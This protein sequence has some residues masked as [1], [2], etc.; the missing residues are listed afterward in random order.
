MC[1]WRFVME[2]KEPRV[3]RYYKWKQAPNRS[4]RSQHTVPWERN[5]K[6]GLRELE[7]YDFVTFIL[8]RVMMDEGSDIASPKHY[9]GGHKKWFY[10][11]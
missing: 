4:H 6:R 7:C 9:T 5:R 10:G 8:N 3:E 1:W 11:V 2:T